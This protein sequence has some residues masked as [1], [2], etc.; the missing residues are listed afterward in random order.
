[1]QTIRFTTHHPLAKRPTQG[2]EQAAGF[3]LYAAD[4]LFDFDN[5]Q[6]I[7]DTGLKV[8]FNLGQVLLIYGRAGL[9]STCGI[10]LVT[11]VGVIEG[12]HRGPL[13]IMLNPRAVASTPC[14]YVPAT[15]FVT[16]TVT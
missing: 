15:A 2:S 10:N 14:K 6:V 16:C 7:V 3:V 8:S 12:N 9:T 13:K 11:M 1:M 4:V 5:N